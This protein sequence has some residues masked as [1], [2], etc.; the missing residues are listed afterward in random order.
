MGYCS[1]NK[2]SAVLIKCLTFGGTNAS[3]EFSYGYSMDSVLY[4]IGFSYSNDFGFSFTFG[5]ADNVLLKLNI[6]SEVPI[7]L[8]NIGYATGN[9]KPFSLL[10]TSNFIHFASNEDES[11]LKTQI[12]ID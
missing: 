12:I 11:T 1:F 6:S 2:T 10:L 4:A 5:R 3:E 7:L 9:E 8:K